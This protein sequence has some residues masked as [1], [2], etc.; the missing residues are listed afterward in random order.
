[1][2]SLVSIHLSI[3]VLTYGVV[4]LHMLGAYYPCMYLGQKTLPILS[5]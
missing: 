5:A 4:Y 1:M 2:W 3:Y